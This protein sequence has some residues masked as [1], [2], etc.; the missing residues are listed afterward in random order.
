MQPSPAW[1]SA[2]ILTWLRVVV[3]ARHMKPRRVPARN[4]PARLC[5]G[6]HLKCLLLAARIS[7]NRHAQC[8]PRDW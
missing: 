7:R 1:R 6:G 4:L 5:L 8:E 2:A 3:E